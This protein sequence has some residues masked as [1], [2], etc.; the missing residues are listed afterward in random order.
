[1]HIEIHESNPIREKT[2]HFQFVHEDSCAEWFVNFA[3]EIC[4]R[5]F[6]FEVNANGCMNVSFRKDRYDCTA[7]SLEDVESLEIQT[8][9]GQDMWE[10]DYTVPFALL[11]KYIPGYTFQK[12]MMIKANFYKCGDKTKYPHFGMWNKVEVEKPDFHRPEFFGEIVLDQMKYGSGYGSGFCNS[13][14]SGT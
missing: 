5:Y 6:N 12:G 1:M 10:V 13:V 7:L 14:K 4:D 3:P 8:Q 9:I 11:Q 2:E